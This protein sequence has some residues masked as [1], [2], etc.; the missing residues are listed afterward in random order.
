MPSALKQPSQG[1]QAAYERQVL[2]GLSAE[3]QAARWMLPA[4][5][6]AAIRHPL[7][8]LRDMGRRLGSW[9]RD[10]REIALSRELVNGHGWDDVREVLLHEMAHQVAHEGLGAISQTAHG[11]GFRQACGFLRAN[12][13]ASGSYLPLHA[14]LNQGDALSG[15]DRIVVKIHKL[16]A[17][18]ESS[19]PNEAH[20]AMC[21]AHALI[22]R[23]Q[24][25][26]I[27]RGVERA[28]TSIFLGAPRL[29]HFREAYHLA[30]LLQDYYFVQGV[31]TP[32][33]V[34]AKGRMGR[35]LEISGTPKNVLMAEYVYEAIRRYIDTA[36]QDYRGGRTLGRYRKTDFAIGVVQG[37][38]GTLQ[39]ASTAAAGGNRLP[40]PV[41]DRALNRY[42]AHRYPRLSSVS[43]HALRHDARIVADGKAKGQ[44]L[45]IAK[46]IGGAEGFGGK[47]LPDQHQQ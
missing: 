25:D 37:F 45:V 16:M 7:F 38:R 24:V 15:S 22:A 13:A 29:R 1:L 19:N 32:S 35:V 4:T 17:L 18:A 44:R 27:D 47:L 21:K 6:Q 34:L 46:G 42:V 43:R 9:D 12:P 20:A 33:W 10:K 36:W 5:L 40:V 14:R 11:D 30:H 28:Y 39:G 3:W 2:R 41:T 8:S 23:H 31:W 26:L